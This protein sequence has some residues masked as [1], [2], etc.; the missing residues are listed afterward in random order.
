VGRASFSVAC[1]LCVALAGAHPAAAQETLE[2]ISSWSADAG[3]GPAALM[4]M[5]A[6]LH[7]S[8]V[9]VNAVDIN[10]GMDADAVLKNRL[11]VGTPPDAFQTSAGH[12]LIDP[13]VL[14][15]RMED[16]SSLYASEGWAS[17]FPKAA[18]ALLSGRGGTWSVPIAVR[19]VNLLWYVPSRVKEW[20]ITIP[21][22]LDDLLDTCAKLRDKG[23][24]H[25]LALGD[26]ETRLDLWES[27][28]LGML[29]ATGWVHLWNGKLKLDDPLVVEVWDAFGRLLG[30]ADPGGSGLSWSQTVD[31]VAKGDAAFAIGGDRAAAYLSEVL[32]LIPGDDFGWAPSPGTR[33]LFLMACDSFAAPRGAKHRA[34]ALAWLRFLGSREAQARFNALTG[35]IPARLDADLTAYGPYAQSAARDWKSNTIVGSLSHGMVAPESFTRQL[36]TVMEIYLDG[37]N[38]Q[39]AAYAMQALADQAHLG[40]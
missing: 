36:G 38:A 4:E 1:A 11:L 20:G 29:G 8:T 7:P 24:E 40:L 30:F 5:Y 34:A 28:A 32:G 23:I 35:A 37:M 14:A 26:T 16:L 6:A 22:T 33:G 31:K 3:T 2:I 21:R 10:A 25:P 9:V 27:V 12:G 13:W 19:R 39:A 18:V 17:K 15:G